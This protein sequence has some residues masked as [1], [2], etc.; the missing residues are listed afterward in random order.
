M[1]R[2]EGR[3][4]PAWMTAHN[5]TGLWQSSLHILGRLF[6]IG[7]VLVLVGAVAASRAILPPEN[8]KLAAASIIHIS[9][10]AS[11]SDIAEL[12]RQ[13]G[14]IRSQRAFNAA[15]RLMGLEQ[16]LKAGDYQ[17]SPG[18]DLLKVMEHLEAGQVATVR[19]T[20]PEGLTLDAVA[21]RLAAQGLV[22]KERFLTLAR[23]DSLIYGDNP[24]I[25]KPTR[26]LEGYLFPDT[27]FFVRNQPEEEIIKRM[28][29]RFVQVVEPLKETASLPAGF[30][31]HDIVTLAS[32][33]EKEVMVA[34]EAPIVSAVFWNRL[35][36]DMPLQSDPTVQFILQESRKLYYSDLATDSPYNTYKYKGLPPGPIASPGLNSIKAALEPA[37]VDYLYFVAKGDGTHAFSRTF[38][39]HRQARARY[40]Y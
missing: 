3:F 12:L 10:G 26:S 5:L 1:S 31:W 37:D 7:L 21:D 32:I 11:G 33:I 20:I 4:R 2:L 27:Y 17:L 34:R 28:V 25:E 13:E 14:I 29:H 30:T 24:P 6:C 40:G 9:P 35:R 8:A 22:D 39:Q 16:S 36:I 19:V 15:V 23:D 18:M 38:Q